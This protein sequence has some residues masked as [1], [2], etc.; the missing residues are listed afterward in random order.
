[1]FK[2]G[3][4]YEY[5]AKAIASYLKDA[6]IKVDQRITLSADTTENEY[7]EGRLSELRGEVEDIEVY[8]RYLSA[9]RSAFVKG[10]TPDDFKERF[11]TELDPSFVEKRDLLNALENPAELSEEERAA[12]CEKSE[13]LL[14]GL[15]LEDLA[16]WIVA[17]EFAAETLS[18][19]RIEPGVEIRDLLNDPILRISIDPENYEG[20]MPIKRTLSVEFDK[21]YD[22]YIDEFT[23]PL[24]E[25]LDEEFQESYPREFLKIMALGILITDLVEDSPPGKINLQAF[26]ERCEMD[27]EKEGDILSID[28]T[29][30]A[31]DIARVLEKNG[32]I[33]MKGDTIKWK[34]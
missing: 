31:E 16:E 9:L 26:A 29:D 19:N 30:V 27:L 8:E 21:Q 7:L 24:F 34:S 4:Y 10:A 23:S 22:L 5:E 11:L 6:G 14:G 13:G 17:F 3:E 2:L 32:I 1:M 20:D 25:E 15:A 28:A 12:A 18:R 33:K